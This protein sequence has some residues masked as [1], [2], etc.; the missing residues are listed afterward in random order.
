[1]EQLVG[2]FE[3]GRLIDVLVYLFAALITASRSV[4]RKDGLFLQFIA[5]LVSHIHRSL[6]SNSLFVHLQWAFALASHLGGDA[7][8]LP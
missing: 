3:D 8:L 6:R 4:S 2:L 5:A 7:S 1:M